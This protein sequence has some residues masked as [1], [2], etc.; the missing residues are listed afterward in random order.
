MEELAWAPWV[1]E[2]E[3][4]ATAVSREGGGRAYVGHE[5]ETKRCLAGGRRIGV[6]AQVVYEDVGLKKER[7]AD[8]VR[9]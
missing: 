9:D 5:D 1:G 6:R 8:G 2:G 3:W 4:D 7:S